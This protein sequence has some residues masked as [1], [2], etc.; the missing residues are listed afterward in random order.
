MASSK[1]SPFTQNGWIHELARLE[2]HPEAERLFGLTN[3]NDPSQMVEEAT[4]QFMTALRER[5]TDFARVLNGYSE[6]GQK[7][8]EVK[9][10][11]VAQT[12]ADFMLFRNQVKLLFTNAAHGMI[13]VSFAK[14]T[15]TT[16]AV[17]APAENQILAQ[18]DRPQEILAQ[19]GPFREVVWTYQNERVSSDQVARFYFS[20]FIRATR[21]Q[22]KAKAGN[23]VLLDQI[24]T[25][26]QE[27]GID[28]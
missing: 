6:G 22:R 19:L 21:D 16:V 4:V 20:E 25:L 2:I 23:Q 9:I 11:S 24:R 1:D 12:A 7:F 8:Q 3:S 18:Y 5:F 10:Y 27:R 15:R 17:D 28:L 14:H 13:Q 26:L